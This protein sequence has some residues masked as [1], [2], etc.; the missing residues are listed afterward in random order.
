MNLPTESE[1]S[2]SRNNLLN[3]ARQVLKDLARD[4]S[5][6]EGPWGVERVWLAI[7]LMAPVPAKELARAVRLPIPVVSALRREAEKRNLLKRGKGI[8]LTDSGRELADNLWGTDHLCELIC[9]ECGGSTLRQPP[10]SRETSEKL[11]D[12]MD[13]RPEVNV[14]LDQ[15][16]GTIHTAI[17]R[18]SMGLEYGAILGRHVLFLGDDDL[19]SLTAGFL[20]R[21]WFG[22]KAL[23]KLHLTVIDC[24]QRFCEYIR[25]VAETEQFPLSVV[26]ADLRNPI[27]L[28]VFAHTFY[29]DPPYTPA[30]LELFCSRALDNITC[31]WGA[32]GIVSFSLGMESRRLQIQ[33]M[34][35]DMG[36]YI[37]GMWPGVNHYHGGTILANR[38][39]LMLLHVDS[40]ADST[41][42]QQ[43]K[44]SLYTRDF[45]KN[46]S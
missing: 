46:N 40:A 7:T 26:E 24:D 32:C 19:L 14:T 27:K 29:T 17:Y 30:G 20:I 43:F 1:D 39:D 6:A 18:I 5:L 4:T 12:L 45:K 31:E 25:K 38:S 11:L 15:S 37:L 9:P 22:K 35:T 36:L 28:P 8:E 44:E 23:E 2:S 13:N 10:I 33:Q 42:K 41:I 34:L 21:E 16:H 3:P